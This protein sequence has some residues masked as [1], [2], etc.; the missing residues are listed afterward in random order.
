MLHGL[1]EDSSR[2]T[3]TDLIVVVSS[4]AL[5][6]AAGLA[7]LAVLRVNVRLYVSGGAAWR[8]IL[9]HTVRIAGAVLVFWALATQGAGALLGGFAGFLAARLIARQWKVKPS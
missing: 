7:Y 2:L 6:L 9:L 3:P 8:P 4:A 5:G 1:E